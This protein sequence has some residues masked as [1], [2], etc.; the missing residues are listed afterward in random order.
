MSIS[1][2]AIIYYETSQDFVSMTELTDSGDNQLF[3]SVDN[4]WSNRSGFKASVKPDGVITGFKISPAA[5]A[6]QS[7][8][9]LGTAYQG[10]EERTVVAVSSL[11][12][13]RPTTNNYK[14]VSVV[15]DDSQDIG[16][17]EGTE[18][19][20]F[21]TTRGAA[22]GPP[23]IPVGQIELGQI[24]YSS[25]TSAVITTSEIKQVTGSSIERYNSPVWTQMNSNVDSGVLGKAGVQFT[26]ALPAIH[27]GG[28]PKKV[29]AE[30]YT[31][32]FTELIDSTDFV[33][34][35]TTHSSTSQQVYGRTLGGSSSTLNQSSWT[36]Y[37]TDGISDPIFLLKNL[38]LW[39]KFK[40]NRLDDPYILQ[41]GKFGVS[42][43]FPSST[44]ASAS[45]TVTSLVEAQEVTVF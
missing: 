29:Y 38:E 32:V 37:P 35:E 26:S 31:P 36:F 5:T 7:D 40:Q 6:D 21:S 41:Q 34:A 39:F 45:A 43:T 1:D 24:K 17:A 4:L 2:D 20:S 27:T 44:L 9:A 12:I 30:Y 16:I 28:L 18:G 10:G 42:R 13:P 14:I 15:L 11:D 3:E 25:T 23:F 19:T 22:G 8:I 33:P